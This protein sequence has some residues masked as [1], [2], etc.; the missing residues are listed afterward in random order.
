MCFLLMPESCDR[1]S[2]RSRHHNRET[3]ATEKK[4][5]TTNRPV[6]LSILGFNGF[7]RKKKWLETIQNPRHASGLPWYKPPLLKFLGN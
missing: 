6:K 5:A 3:G 2:F 1:I 4:G 7:F